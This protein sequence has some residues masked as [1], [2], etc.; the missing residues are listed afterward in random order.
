MRNRHQLAPDVIINPV[1]RVGVN[2]TVADPQPGAHRL[3]DLPQHVERRLHTVLRHLPRVPGS[4]HLV[5]VEAED[6]VVVFGG[7]T[8][9]TAAVRPVDGARLDFDAADEVQGVPVV[10]GEARDGADSQQPA[11]EYALGTWF[12]GIVECLKAIG[13]LILLCFGIL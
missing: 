3:G 7:Q 4:L 13:E 8:D 6:V 11:A 12:C 9:E 10:E 1:H 5:S 2:E